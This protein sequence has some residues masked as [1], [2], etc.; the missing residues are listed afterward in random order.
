MGSTTINLNQLQAKTAELEKTTSKMNL[1]SVFAERTRSYLNEFTLFL[2][3]FNSIP[4]FIHEI[5]IDC[6][7]ANKWFIENY[8]GFRPEPNRYHFLT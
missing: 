4:N 8:K 7:R 6:K 5:N 1:G 3:H 2:A